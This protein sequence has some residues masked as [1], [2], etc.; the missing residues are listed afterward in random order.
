MS[1]VPVA[2]QGLQPGARKGNAA[3]GSPTGKRPL[4]AWMKNPATVII[5]V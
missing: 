3:E 5:L 1:T 2:C 4:G